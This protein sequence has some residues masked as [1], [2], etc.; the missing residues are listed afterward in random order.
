MNINKKVAILFNEI[1]DDAPKDEQDVLLEAKTVAE[2]LQSIGYDTFDIGFSLAADKVAEKMRA[3]NP[4]FVFNL[5]ETV[6]GNGRLI[7]MAPSLLEHLNIPYT[8]CS[9]EAIFITSN[10]LLTKKLLKASG[11]ATPE[12]LT[13]RSGANKDL[14]IER[15]LYIVKSVW[16][17]ASNWFNDDSIVKVESNDPANL[18]E[19]LK[20][21]T[22]ETGKDFFA[23]RYIE[24][25]EFNISL[26]AGR[27]LP[28]PEIKFVDFPADQ[29]KV[30]NFRAK[31]EEDSFE[32]SHTPRSFDFPQEDS[33]LLDKL[34]EIALACWDLFELAGYGRVDF[35]VDE[36]GQPFVLEIN[37]NPCISPDS[38]FR[39][40][41]E[42][43]GIAFPQVLTSIIEHSITK[44]F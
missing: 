5:A 19:I 1:P 13:L 40:A 11:I 23:E 9:T 42:R 37:T 41:T 8:G 28:I 3:F 14:K 25:R 22:A 2:G 7:H 35:R 43:A 29:Y 30:V 33:P 27:V 10:K 34:Q 15:G 24:G 21:R 20:K 18:L 38:G 44:T 26:L 4:A 32:F 17:H 16:E 36:S 39:A 6:E 12:W 31:W